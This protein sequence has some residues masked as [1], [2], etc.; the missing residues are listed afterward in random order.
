MKTPPDSL[1]EHLTNLAGE[2]KVFSVIDLETTGFSAQFN[3]IIEIGIVQVTT[4]GELVREWDTLVKPKGE[5]KG[6]SIHGITDTDVVDA[7]S[8]ESVAAPLAKLLHGTCMVA[9]N[10]PFEI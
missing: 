6:T 4:R 3:E 9:Q 2:A 1:Y 8:F 7:P 5:V 10:T